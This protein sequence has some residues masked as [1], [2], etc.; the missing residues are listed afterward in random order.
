MSL[1]ASAATATSAASWL[2]PDLRTLTATAIY[3]VVF[4]F[5]FVE[6]GLLVGVLLPG[7]TVLFAAGLLSANP[8]VGLR[9]AWLLL[10]ATLAAVAGD[11]VG[12][13]S[14]HRAGRP[15]L[16][17]RVATGRFPP[18]VLA[19][20]E[21]LGQ[22]WGALAVIIARW[23]PWVRTF[24]PILAGVAR[25]PYR[26]FVLANVA[27]AAVWAGGLLGIGRLAA[28]LPWVR[29]AAFLVAGGVVAASVLASV[30]V[31]ARARGTRP[32][33]RPPRG[34]RGR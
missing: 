10:G 12:Y 4:G 14:G 11:A 28:T 15:W 17:R 7:D 25:M 9:L 24:T 16:D 26:R 5:L 29:D 23:I 13:L 2:H 22:R 30:I 31:L 3:A 6:S 32:G 34:P 18:G 21:A 19:R 20:T 33:T 27:G 1:L 8:S